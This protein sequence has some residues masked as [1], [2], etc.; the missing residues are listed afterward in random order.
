MKEVI[1]LTPGPFLKRDYERFGIELLK[2][3]FLIK[4]LDIT[5]WINPRLWQEYSNKVFKCEEYIAV[6][7]ENSFLNSISQINSPIVLDRLAINNKTNWM[8][9]ILREKKS[10]FVYS[11]LNLVPESKRNILQLFKILFIDLTSPIKLL[12]KVNKKLQKIKFNLMK[13]ESDI[14]I[15]AGVLGSKSTKTKNRILAHS[16]DY[17]IY[18]SLKNKKKSDLPPYAVFLEDNMTQ[19]SDYSILNILPPVNE[20]Q[21][22]PTLIKFLK[23]FEADTGLKVKI[24]IHPK[25]SKDFSNLLEDFE[26]HKGN[27]AEIVKDATLVLLHAS[28]SVSYAILFNK[29]TLFLTSYELNK[30]WLGSRIDNLARV[31]NSKLINMTSSINDTFKL[32][33]FLNIDKEKYKNYIDQYLKMPNSLEIP[34]WDIFTKYISENFKK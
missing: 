18:L 10:L 6:T 7:S 28:T 26:C 2:K 19:D 12:N 34:L 23:K 3:N 20:S 27:T 33:S 8:R 17:D 24:A 13:S 5:A 1:I 25:S 11:N 22:F 14:F 21:Y 4:I 16:M 30:S 32:D 9:K 29:P 31:I 15:A